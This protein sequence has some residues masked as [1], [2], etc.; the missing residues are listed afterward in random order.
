M[1]S[2]SD[3]TGFDYHPFSLL[4]FPGAAILDFMSVT[5]AQLFHTKELLIVTVSKLFFNSVTEQQQQLHYKNG[6]PH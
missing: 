5:V 2:V 1:I 4:N 6:R 3:K